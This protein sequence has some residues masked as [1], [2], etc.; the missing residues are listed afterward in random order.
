MDTPKGAAASPLCMT[1]SMPSPRTARRVAACERLTPEHAVQRQRAQAEP[2]VV[3]WKVERRANGQELISISSE[4]SSGDDNDSSDSDFGAGSVAGTSATT[5]H[6]SKRAKHSSR[7]HDAILDDSSSSSSSSSDE[8]EEITVTTRRRVRLAAAKAARSESVNEPTGRR[9]RASDSSAP[10][11]K[12]ARN[13]III[14]DDDDEINNSSSS[15]SDDDGNDGERAHGAAAALLGMATRSEPRAPVIYSIDSDSDARSERVCDVASVHEDED[16]DELPTAAVRADERASTAHLSEHDDSSFAFEYRCDEADNG[17]TTPEATGSSCGDTD[18]CVKSELEPSAVV[19]TEPLARP[20]P[21]PLSVTVESVAVA[22]AVAVKAESV[23]LGH[24]A[25]LS[26]VPI[27]RE[28]SAATR[29]V[30]RK[31]IPLMRRK[32]LDEEDAAFLL[33]HGIS[34]TPTSHILGLIIGACVARALMQRETSHPH[35]QLSLTAALSLSC[36]SYGQSTLTG[37]SGRPRPSS[38][39]RSSSCFGAR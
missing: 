39:A 33:F 26:S 13:T 14:L 37:A 34:E 27:K 35:S 11:R 19:K 36:D 6:R 5:K 16:D 31:A 3:A 20:T 24:D 21:L 12:R 1:T 23:A 9:T 29:V 2:I 8:D 38:L 28:L 7:L 15:D 10:S 25:E 4:E 18:V 17:D 30:P 32:K 22:K